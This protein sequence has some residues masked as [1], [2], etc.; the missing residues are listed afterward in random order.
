MPRHKTRSLYLPCLQPLT[1]LLPSPMGSRD[2]ARQELGLSPGPTCYVAFAVR[3]IPETPA[4]VSQG[5][6]MWRKN[7]LDSGM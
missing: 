7:Y 6:S 3:R 1:E 5:H 2:C 4:L